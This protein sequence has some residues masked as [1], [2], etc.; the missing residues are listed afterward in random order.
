MVN[1]SNSDV[2]T[3]PADE[4]VTQLLCAI[5]LLSSQAIATYSLTIALP[6]HFR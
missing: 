6:M 2:N 4:P 3:V 1:G 5:T